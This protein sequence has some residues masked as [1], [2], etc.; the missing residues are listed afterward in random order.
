MPQYQLVPDCGGVRTQE[1]EGDN[2]AAAL[3]LAIDLSL[4][5]SH[6]YEGGVYLFSL[7]HDA[8]GTGVWVIDR[9]AMMAG[10]EMLN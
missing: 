2:P 9:L 1:F 5:E 6:V 10:S 3:G 8:H 4:D 7:H